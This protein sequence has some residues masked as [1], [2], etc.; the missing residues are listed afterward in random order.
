MREHSDSKGE[1]KLS[2]NSEK[3]KEHSVPHTYKNGCRNDTSNVPN[4]ELNHGVSLFDNSKG[5][6]HNGMRYLN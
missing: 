3:R 4:S 2:I 6:S 1:L 5:K